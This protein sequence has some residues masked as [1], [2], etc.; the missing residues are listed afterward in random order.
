LN[1]HSVCITLSRHG[2]SNNVQ[3]VKLLLLLLRDHAKTRPQHIQRPEA[4]LLVHCSHCHGY[5][6]FIG[7]GLYILLINQ[8]FSV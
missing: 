5:S 8:L 4:S 3:L 6:K 1:G 7:Q 2:T